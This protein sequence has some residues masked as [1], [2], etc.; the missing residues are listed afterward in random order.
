MTLTPFLDAPMVIQMHVSAALLAVML[1]PVAL[2][3]RSR[4]RWH[5]LAGYGWVLAMTLTA[6][7]SFGI[8]G[9]AVLGPFSPIHL[10][11]IVVLVSL[12]QGVRAARRG[13]IT[14]HQKTLR[15]LYW[16]G[17]CVAGLFTF[18]PG[19]L[20]SE[21]LLGGRS[22]LAYA[23]IAAAGSALVIQALW[24]RFMTRIGDT[25]GAGRGTV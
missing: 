3:R 11:S 4:D 19:R 7:S 12:W 14:A 23:V 13:D 22:D 17:L 24:P 21:A 6:L 2:W 15:G 9:F 18:L 10:L 20:M 1:G 8:R 16:R 25:S 5:R